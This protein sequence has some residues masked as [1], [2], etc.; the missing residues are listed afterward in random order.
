[1]RL[2]PRHYIL[3]AVIIAIFVVN[4]VRNRHHQTITSAPPVPVVV[5]GPRMDTPAWAAFDVAAGLRDS[6]D[7]QFQPALHDLQQQVDATHDATTTPLTGCQTWLLFYRQS[8][9]HP[10]KDLDWKNR[11]TSHVNGCVKYHADTTA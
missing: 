6:S 9:I 3:C 11:S 8:V 4:I 10:S 2:R 1:M 7:A 5:M